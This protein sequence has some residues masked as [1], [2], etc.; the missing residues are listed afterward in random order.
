MTRLL[1]ENRSKRSLDIVFGESDEDENFHEPMQTSTNKKS[2]IDE[3]AKFSA[4]KPKQPSCKA[5]LTFNDDSSNVTNSSFSIPLLDN[6]VQ[7]TTLISSKVILIFGFQI[8]NCLICF[9]FK[10]SS[11]NSKFKRFNI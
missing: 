7:E 4:S 8:F 10:R 9:Y 6:T 3:S 11:T 2:K 1:D 5:S